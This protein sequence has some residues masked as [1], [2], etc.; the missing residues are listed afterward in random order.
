MSESENALADVKMFT[1]ITE[2][3]ELQRTGL[4]VIKGALYKL[5]LW[6]SYSNPDVPYFV[7]VYVQEN[8]VWRR[9]QDSPFAEGPNGD[10]ALRRAMAFLVERLAA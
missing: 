5:E 6:H 10:E 2:S 8:G 7:A 4:I 9:M 3:W 1:G